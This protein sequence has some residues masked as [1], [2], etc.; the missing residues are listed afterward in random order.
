MEPVKKGVTQ[1][2][3]KRPLR[4]MLAIKCH[5]IYQNT[6]VNKPNSTFFHII[7]D[8]DTFSSASTTRE[9]AV[10]KRNISSRG[11]SSLES[12]YT[13]KKSSRIRAIFVAISTL[14]YESRNSK[15]GN[16]AQ[17]QDHPVD[18]SGTPSQDCCTN[19]RAEVKFQNLL[20]A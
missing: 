3:R 4:Q 5:D 2:S 14:F 18:Y 11:P 7:K 9:E 1:E 6:Q 10:V 16:S 8:H 12:S 20:N 15:Q 13:P 19:A 17:S